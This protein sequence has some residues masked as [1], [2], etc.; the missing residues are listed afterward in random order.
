MVCVDKKNF[1]CIC[2]CNMTTMY[3]VWGIVFIVGGLGSAGSSGGVGF[4]GFFQVLMGAGMLTV[5]C[6]S[7]SI[8]L[9]KIIYYVYLAY[10]V[11][12]L[13]CLIIAIIVILAV[14]SVV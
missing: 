1:K 9:R 7:K 10:C 14:D 5:L 2:G 12:L 13:L 4:M 8:Q 6:N 3:M 11:I